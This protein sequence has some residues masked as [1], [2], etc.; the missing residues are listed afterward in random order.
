MTDSDIFRLLRHFLVFR[1]HWCH[2]D[3]DEPNEPD[4]PVVSGGRRFL[5]I[6]Y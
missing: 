2:A 4:E 6:A 5:E 1:S 3:L